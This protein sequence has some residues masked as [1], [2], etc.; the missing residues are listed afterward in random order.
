MYRS[1]EYIR[2]HTNYDT[3][4]I[5]DYILRHF[6]IADIYTVLGLSFV[7]SEQ[8]NNIAKSIMNRVV[9]IVSIKNTSQLDFI[10]S[11]LCCVP[12]E[13]NIVII[14]EDS[15][16]IK[17]LLKERQK[18]EIVS[19]S[20]GGKDF[21]SMMKTIL[22]YIEIYDYICL[23]PLHNEDDD[24]VNNSLEQRELI[25]DNLLVNQQYVL[26]IISIL[27]EHPRMGVAF[28]PVPIYGPYMDN[29]FDRW[30]H[31]FEAVKTVCQQLGIHV[32]LAKEKQ[33]IML[34]EA[35]WCRR[36]VLLPFA[37]GLITQTSHIRNKPSIGRSIVA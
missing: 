33:P 36:Q 10:R 5:W 6:H 25:W 8:Q 22:S 16:E 28:P 13:A 7:V 35:F 4:L 23:L 18:I 26:N 31:S 1:I 27:E 11:R 14:S 9:V 24:Y 2:K 20:D 12:E 19:F 3:N 17:E 30:H 15:Y 37:K 34:G 29:I 21:I 32:P